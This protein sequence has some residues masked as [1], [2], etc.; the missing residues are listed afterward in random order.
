MSSIINLTK[1]RKC[2]RILL[3]GCSNA[4]TPGWGTVDI[5][6]EPKKLRSI[7][8][9]IYRRELARYDGSPGY[10]GIKH[11]VNASTSFDKMHPHHHKD[12]KRGYYRRNGV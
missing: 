8:Y 12:L 7:M 9:F 4:V 3:N 1:D 2:G 11:W 10:G 6:I 5:M